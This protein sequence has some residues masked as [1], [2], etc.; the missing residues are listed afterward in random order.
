MLQLAGRIGLGVDVGNLLEFQRALERDRI[1]Q[2][3]PQEQGVFLLG[4][5]RG[6]GDQLRLERKRGRE[7]LRQVPQAL[8]MLELFLP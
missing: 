7:R 2:S 8:K 6:P 4:E 1:V 5:A 3:A